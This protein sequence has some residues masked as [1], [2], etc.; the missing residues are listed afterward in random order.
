MASAPSGAA[1]LGVIYSLIALAAL[2]IAARIYLRLVI[3]KQKLVVAD[4][5]RIA[6]WCSA[7]ATASFDILFLKED[8]LDPTLNYTLVNWDA[9]PEKFERVLKYMWAGIIPFF[10]TFYLCKASLLVVYLQLFPPF[11]KK[12]RFVVWTVTG[13][14]EACEGEI[15]AMNF[16]VAWTLHF[17]GSLFLFALPF[18]VLYKLNMP[19][20][21]K[22]SVYCIFLLGIIDIA[23]SLTRFL[24]IQLG[25]VGD[26]RSITTIELWSAL[27]AYIGLIIACLPA[28]RPYLRRKGSK[29][30]YAESGRPAVNSAA[31]P[32]RVGQS[33]FEEL[34][35]TPSLE[36]D[37]GPRTWAGSSS[38]DIGAG[39][40][41]KKSTRSDVELVTLDASSKD[42]THAL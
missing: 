35:E 25:N 30:D 36:G 9:P 32:R 23:M 20:R 29:Y 7:F 37:T 34:D 40:S 22:I 13:P 19:T 14:E 8:V 21:V 28:L 3:Q 27:D 18:F 4:W 6:A 5:L 11:M 10:T 42:R 17:V 33:G 26:F 31:P 15:M 41:D 1:V 38:P 39:W 12:R 16:Q 24:T 2:I